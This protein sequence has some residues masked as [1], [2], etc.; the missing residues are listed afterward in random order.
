[1][2]TIRFGNERYSCVKPRPRG[3]IAS[4]DAVKKVQQGT[5]EEREVSLVPLVRQTIRAR[6]LAQWERVNCSGKFLNS[7]GRGKGIYVLRK[8]RRKV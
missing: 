3:R 6:G 1:V 8:E 7:D 4:Q 2:I 5:R